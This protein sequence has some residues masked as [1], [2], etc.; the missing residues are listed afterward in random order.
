M[1]T[2]R[3]IAIADIEPLVE[4]YNGN[5]AAIARA[6][7]VNRSTVWARVQESAHLQTALESAR[8]TMLDNAESV[9]YKAVLD[10][11][12]AELLFFLKTQGKSRGYT[13]RMEVL[14]EERLKQELSDA[15][16]QLERSLPAEEYQRVLAI[17][18]GK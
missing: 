2:P 7:G 5:V 15:L 12:T 8:E 11:E 6:L 10:G 17:L 18:A 3:K 4:K 13:E 1:T 16:N 14:L 9:L